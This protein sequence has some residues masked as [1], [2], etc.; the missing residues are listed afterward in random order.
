MTKE[1]LVAKIAHDI[2]CYNASS[3]QAKLSLLQDLII[4]TLPDVE[5]G[6]SDYMQL[7][8]VRCHKNAEQVVAWLEELMQTYLNLPKVKDT[9]AHI[10]PAQMTK[11]Y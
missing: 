6:S 1:Q 9:L 10:D 11:P 5:H 8:S 3:S 7:M 2:I 4:E